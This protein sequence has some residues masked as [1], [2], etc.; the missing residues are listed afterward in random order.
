MKCDRLK[1]LKNLEVAVNT[2]TEQE[3]I[4]AED[5]E[6]N[7]YGFDSWEEVYLKDEADA[8]IAELKQ[9]FEVVQALAQDCRA[10]QG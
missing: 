1:P 8:A 7:S 9:I 10:V 3:M 6:G 2:T 5:S 4:I